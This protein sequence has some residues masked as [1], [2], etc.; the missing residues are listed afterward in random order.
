M[1]SGTRIYNVNCAIADDLTSAEIEGRR[2]IRAFLDMI[3]KYGE[4]FKVGL[5]G[6]PSYIGIRETRHVGCLYQ[7]KDEDA[8]YGKRFKDAI[9]N[10]SYCLDLHHQN[11]PGITFRYL[12]GSE[13]YSRPGYPEVEGRWRDEIETNPT[14]YQ[15]PLGSIIPKQS[16]NVILAG[17]MLDASPISF[18]GI[19]VMVNMNQIGEAAGVTAYLALDQ[20]KS[21]KQVDYVDV[22]K[23]LSK[24]GSIII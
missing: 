8:M 9:A 2:Q 19:R 5:T 21:I 15:V 22:R 23:R 20:N 6:L 7:V 13:R 16:D 17:R 11:K 12:D 3:R 14:F 18:S 1:L 4:N 10:G 24:D